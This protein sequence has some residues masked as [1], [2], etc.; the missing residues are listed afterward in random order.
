MRY[1]LALR[2]SLDV[3]LPNFAIQN[4]MVIAVTQLQ[5]YKSLYDSN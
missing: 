4:Q 5:R 3:L 1:L 2:Y